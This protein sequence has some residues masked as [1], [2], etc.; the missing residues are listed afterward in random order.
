VRTLVV[1][2]S[3]VLLGLC[4][5][6]LAFLLWRSITRA[7]R[8]RRRKELVDAGA[9]A[10]AAV[11]ADP[12]TLDTDPVAI[13]TLGRL[14]PAELD[15][16]VIRLARGL[17]GETH[18]AVVRAADRLGVV[19]RAERLTTDRRW[20]RRLRGARMLT[21]LQ[22]DREHMD[23]LLDDAH[24]LVRAQAAEWTASHPAPERIRAVV[25]L[26]ADEDPVTVHAAQDALIRIGGPAERPIAE[27]LGATAA[28]SRARLAVME[29]AGALHSPLF[30]P[31]ACELAWAP[32]ELV[33]ARAAAI[34][35]AAGTDGAIAVLLSLLDDS[36]PGVRRAAADALGESGDWHAAGRL[37]HVLDDDDFAVR[38]SAGLSLLRLGAP[39]LVALRAAASS[40]TD[41]ARD[42]AARVLE[43]NDFEQRW[44][45]R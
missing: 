28:A 2:T 29:V 3:V 9:A 31:P 17:A 14:R 24:P 30:G 25:R 33:R 19:E 10:I 32:E 41:R 40:G 8:A 22:V 20:W 11:A 4:S 37:G 23:R 5:L 26:L 18:D 16:L 42:M 15:D 27:A 38:R 35:G 44:R 7:L 43:Q 12:G 39:G 34:L 45:Q 21:A 36:V 6:M 1:V 13:A